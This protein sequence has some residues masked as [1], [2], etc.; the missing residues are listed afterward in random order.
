MRSKGILASVAVAGA[1]AAFAYLNANTVP[2]DSQNFLQISE[3]EQ[4]FN[5][6]IAKYGR[7]FGTKEEYE[8]RLNNFIKTYKKIIDHNLFDAD[9]Q[10]FTMGLNHMSDMSD[11]E[12]NQLLGNLE[13]PAGQNNEFVMLPTDSLPDSVDW[14]KAGKINGP[15]N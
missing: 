9:E 5:K 14:Y 2:S 3:I 15:K 8:Y 6:F 1:V 13:E 11:A 12:Y 7:S 10:G 4:A